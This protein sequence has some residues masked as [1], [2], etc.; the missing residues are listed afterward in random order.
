MATWIKE[1][2]EAIYLMEGGFYLEKIPKIPRPNGEYQLSVV[3]MRAWFAR[4]DAP[5]GMVISTGLGQPEPQP[6]PGT[7]PGSGNPGGGAPKPRVTFTPAN[8]SNYRAR[9]AGFRIDT[10]VF[11]NTVFSTESAIA[12]FKSP[13][14]R[15]SA[16]YIIDRSGQ[17]YQMVLDQDCAFH[18]GDRDINDRSIGIE[19]EATQTQRGMTPAQE[20]SSVALIRFL[21]RT[22][23]IP[24]N[25]I[26]P[27]RAI[28]QT[29]CPSLVFPDDASFN[30]WVVSN[31]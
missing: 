20:K 3:P 21:L 6:K 23:S 19:H 4:P 27:H 5:G 9:R 28:R 17:I 16:H 15:V 22:Y 10:I 14:S 13:S 7:N 26:L 11:H 1:T 31:F 8:A 12:T 2:D 30:R 18:A 29:S 24:R 25:R